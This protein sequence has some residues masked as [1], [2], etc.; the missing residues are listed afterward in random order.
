DAREAIE[1]VDG[2]LVLS[3]FTGAR[4]ALARVAI[5]A[6]LPVFVDKCISEDPREAED[7]V[8]HAAKRGVPLLS[9]SPYRFAEPVTSA[10]A[11]MRS[12]AY[13][14]GVMLGPRECRDLGDD[15]R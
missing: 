15:P 10:K 8:R 11:L 7:V 2:V 12:D 1:G 5:L 14:F 13:G 6:G 9:C 3:R 4:A